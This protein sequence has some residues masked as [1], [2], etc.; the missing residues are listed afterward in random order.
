[1]TVG[2]PAGTQLVGVLPDAMAPMAMP[3]PEMLTVAG[4]GT[5]VVSV[6]ARGQKMFV[7]AEDAK[8]IAPLGE[9]GN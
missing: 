9:G 5:V 4:D 3:A 7:A 1:M 6:P 8:G 2:W